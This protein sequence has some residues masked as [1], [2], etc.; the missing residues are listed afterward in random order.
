MKIP[1]IHM[2]H[3]FKIENGKIKNTAVV[4]LKRRKQC[5]CFKISVL[6]FYRLGLL[7]I[8]F[9]VIIHCPQHYQSFGHKKN[10]AERLPVSG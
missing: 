6:L 1:D 10:Q 5:F 9:Q 2:N 8:C 7:R 4:L 3:A